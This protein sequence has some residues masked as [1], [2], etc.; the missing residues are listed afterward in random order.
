MTS[1]A[2]TFGECLRVYR[3]AAGLSQEELAERSGVSVRAIG[4]IER[5]RTRWP[6]RDSVRCLADALGLAG[7]ER[8]GFLS[9]ARRPVAGSAVVE[10]VTVPSRGLDAYREQDAARIEAGPHQIPLCQA[11][12]NGF[13][14]ARERV[15]RLRAPTRRQ[16]TAVLLA[17]AALVGVTAAITSLTANQAPAPAISEQIDALNQQLSGAAPTHAM[18]IMQ[19]LMAIAN[20][21]PGT[22]A[23]SNR[24]LTDLISFAVHRSGQPRPA[25]QPPPD[26]VYALHA[27]GGDD[28]DA[29][30]DTPNM[31]K[32]MNGAGLAG[33]NLAGLQFNTASLD[34]ADL[35]GTDL[36]DA[37]LSQ[38]VLTHARLQ[39]ADLTGADLTGADLSGAQLHDADL[40]GA[41]LAGADFSGA[42]LTG[43]TLPCAALPQARH[44]PVPAAAHCATDAAAPGG[45][46]RP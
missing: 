40:R 26:L 7:Q 27:I 32:D 14:H 35:R 25:G 13:P 29:F 9:L 33:L 6:H 39:G 22:E 38:V 34:G 5:G 4:D 2:G 15:R 11:A 45:H 23:V 18:V 30:V 37:G 42:D 10:P 43:A 28:G 1:H 3:A 12:A 21:H 19:R 16:L 17:L 24:V 8:E 20:S 44:V 31:T 46:H 36:R 41:K